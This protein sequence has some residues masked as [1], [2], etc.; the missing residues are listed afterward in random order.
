MDLAYKFNEAGCSMYQDGEMDV[1]FDMFCGAMQALHYS[2]QIPDRDLT[3]DSKMMLL[4]DPSVQRAF[5]HIGVEPRP[6]GVAQSDRKTASRLIVEEISFVWT[7]VISIQQLIGTGCQYDQA[8]WFALVKS[9]VYFNQA[10]ILHSGLVQVG[11]RALERSL[12]LYSMALKQL[13]EFCPK[14][15]LQC[16]PYAITLTCAVLNNTGYLLYETGEFEC[17]RLCFTRMNQFLTQLGPPMST[18]DRKHR[19][20]FGLNVLIFWRPLTAAGAA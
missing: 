19:E 18:E 11:K 10:L 15:A 12:T 8:T 5:D 1:A 20:E 3:I 13:F 14:D 6:I 16:N 17:S 7:R 9:V 4:T 2:C